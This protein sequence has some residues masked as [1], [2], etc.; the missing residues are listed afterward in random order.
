MAEEK[1]SEEVF[2]VNTGDEEKTV[3]VEQYFEN[4]WKI[5]RN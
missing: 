4:P 2:K 1:K 5:N 3:E